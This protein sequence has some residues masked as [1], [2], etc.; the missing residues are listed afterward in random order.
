MGLIKQLSCD[1]GYLEDF[2]LGTG[3]QLPDAEYVNA[4]FS[5]DKLTEFTAALESGNLGKPFYIENTLSYCGTCK[6]L[7]EGKLLHY[8]I[9]GTEKTVQDRCV[10]CKQ[11]LEVIKSEPICPRCGKSLKEEVKGMWD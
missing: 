9:G 6:E 5:S 10:T 3:M 1:C 8:R 7:K 4:N 2:S 11:E